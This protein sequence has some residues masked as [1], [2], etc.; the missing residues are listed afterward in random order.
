[1]AKKET[2]ISFEERL[3]RMR[4]ITELLERKDCPLEQSLILYRE[5]LALA[6]QCREELAAAKHEME[7]LNGADW[8]SFVPEQGQD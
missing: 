7:I 1:M 5:G 8:E 3:A 6:K 4:E 2:K